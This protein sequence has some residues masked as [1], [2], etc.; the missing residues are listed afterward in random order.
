MDITLLRVSDIQEFDFTKIK[1]VTPLKA[2]FVYMHIVFW[3]KIIKL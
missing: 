3:C 2:S 1:T